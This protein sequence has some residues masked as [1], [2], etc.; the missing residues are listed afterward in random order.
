MNSQKYHFFTNS[1]KYIEMN[2]EILF[3]TFQKI[4]N[5]KGFCFK[6]PHFGTSL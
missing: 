5:R 1:M 6:F 3:K 4:E 2:T